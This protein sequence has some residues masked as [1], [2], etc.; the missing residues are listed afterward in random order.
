MKITI[1]QFG[2]TY[3][4]SKQD[5]A[6]SENLPLGVSPNLNKKDTIN[7]VSLMLGAHPIQTLAEDQVD[8]T[9]EQSKLIDDNFSDLI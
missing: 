8:L 1:Q 3:T 7:L 9:P 6:V 4:V 5:G 2:E